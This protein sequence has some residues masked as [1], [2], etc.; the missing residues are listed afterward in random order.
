MTIGEFWKILPACFEDEALERGVKVLRLF[1]LNEIEDK[2]G[3]FWSRDI[4]S[5]WV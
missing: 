3:D 4:N 5:L 1:S 2:L